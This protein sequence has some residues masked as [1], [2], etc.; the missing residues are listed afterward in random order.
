MLRIFSLLVLVLVLLALPAQAQVSPTTPA[1]EY[2]SAELAKSAADYRN[3]LR[4]RFTAKQKQPNLIPRLRKDADEEYRAKRYSQAIDDLTK[5]IAFGADDG[6]V[7]LRL[8][9]ALIAAGNQNVQ[10][11]A[12]NAYTKSTHPVARGTALFLIA[13][14]YDR[15]DKQ[16]EALATFQAGLGLTKSASV[17][18][19]VAQL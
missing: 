10:A 16:K 9:Q 5:A 2:Q 1:P 3:D 4:D 8:A 14:D 6:L 12:Y 18:E 13:R 17:E 7:W 19:R 15:H 11:A